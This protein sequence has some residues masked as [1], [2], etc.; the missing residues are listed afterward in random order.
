MGKKAKPSVSVLKANG[1]LSKPSL[2]PESRK[3]GILKQDFSQQDTSKQVA[4]KLS[5]LQR[6][7]RDKLDGARFRS[8]NEKLY[9]CRGQEAFDMFQGDPSLFKVYHEGYR[10][11]VESWPE[12]PLDQI[13]AWVRS[14][15]A[16]LVVADMGCGEARLA[17]SV[18]NKTYSFDLVSN[19]P[20]VIACDIAHV[21]LT[22][23][24][25]DIVI[26]CLSLM[27]TNISDFLREAHRVLKTNGIMKIA[28][29]QSRFH[30][31][32]SDGMEMFLGSI[33]RAGFDIIRNSC[34]NKMFFLLD[35]KKTNRA[36]VF[37]D[38]VAAKPCVYKKR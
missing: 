15:D 26:F 34:D 23:K 36:A 25:V 37:D 24:S 2:P 16:R 29:V 21:P 38:K 28:E 14:Q 11:Q 18:K 5:D 30:G 13:I 20:S 9:T 3:Q 4:S 32:E 8:L 17:A 12:N 1:S 7:F 6:K 33:E 10:K 22:N 35:C 19:H 27:G 31:S